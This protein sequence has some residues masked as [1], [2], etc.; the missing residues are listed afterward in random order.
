MF[1]STFI[2]IVTFI[3][4][5]SIVTSRSV[6]THI[7][8]ETFIHISTFEGPFCVETVES[9]FTWRCQTFVNVTANK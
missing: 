7:F 9:G 5:Y 8:G 6:G 4:A 1:F 3:G 2:N